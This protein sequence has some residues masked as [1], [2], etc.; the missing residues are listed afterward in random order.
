[1]TY[2]TKNLYIVFFLF[3]LANNLQGQVIK[4]IKSGITE[5]SYTAPH[6]NK[7]YRLKTSK[8]DTIILSQSKDSSLYLSPLINKEFPLWLL[9]NKKKLKMFSLD[10]KRYNLSSLRVGI[11]ELHYQDDRSMKP[12]TIYLNIIK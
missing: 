1:M 8:P 10:D 9:K 5:Y 3:L 6:F 12:L 4:V 2:S 11:Y 7:I